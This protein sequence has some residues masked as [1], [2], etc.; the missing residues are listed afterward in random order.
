MTLA[1]DLQTQYIL[2]HIHA[3]AVNIWMEPSDTS[4]GVTH[5]SACA[6][7]LTKRVCRYTNITTL[8]PVLIG[9]KLFNYKY[10][11]IN[12]NRRLLLL[13]TAMTTGR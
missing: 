7:P 1:L 12:S 10:K 9:T 3:H 4:W 13:Y 2:C 6:Q 11:Y 5:T 8:V